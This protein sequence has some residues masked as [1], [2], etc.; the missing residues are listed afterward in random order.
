MSSEAAPVFDIDVTVPRGEGILHLSFASHA[1]ITALVG[2]SGAGKTSVL[3][4][5]AGLLRPQAGR[6][7]VAGRVLFDSVAGID[8]PPERRGC[9][10]VFQDLRLFPH[11]TVERNLLY[12]A[13]RAGSEPSLLSLL[14]VC[15]LLGIEPLLA[16]PVRRLSGGEAQRVAIGRALLSGARFLLFDEPLSS[17]DPARRGEIM[18]LIERIRD[19]LGLPILYVSHDAAE[20]ERLAGNVVPIG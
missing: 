1:A 8:L 14:D 9:G 11:M 10:Y 18:G 15:A 6:I 20:V 7:A 3:D 13:R 5:V 16:R 19:E 4:M 12:G 2:R 17:L